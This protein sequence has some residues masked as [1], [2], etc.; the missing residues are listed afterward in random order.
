MAFTRSSSASRLA[1]GRIDAALLIVRDGDDLE[2]DQ[3]I[4]TEGYSLALSASHPLATR[5]HIRVEELAGEP[6][7]V[8]RHCELLAETSRFFT[9]RGIR[10][11]FPS[12]TLSDDN[13]LSYVRV[14]LGVTVMPDSFRGPGVARVRLEEFNFTRKIGLIYAPHADAESLA[15]SQAISDLIRAVGHNEEG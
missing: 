15:N 1:R 8:R 7:I 5:E 9:A 3:H 13:A 12:R 11:F 4:L 6:M 14:G 10:P 2:A